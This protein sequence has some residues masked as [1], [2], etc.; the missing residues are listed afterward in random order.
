MSNSLACMININGWSFFLSLSLSTINSKAQSIQTFKHGDSIFHPSRVCMYCT[1]AESQSNCLAM[2]NTQYGFP[3]KNPGRSPRIQL[4][5]R[6]VKNM[7][8]TS[9]VSVR[10]F[11]R[12]KRGVF[13]VLRPSRRVYTLLKPYGEKIWVWKWNDSLYEALIATNFT[14]IQWTLIQQTFIV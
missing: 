13:G 10:E 5:G 6:E 2:W 7:Q 11:S 8:S 1:I 12:R 14:W 9:A 4:W 3:P